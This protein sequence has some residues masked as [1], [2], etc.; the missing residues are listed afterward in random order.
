MNEQFRDDKIQKYYLARVIQKPKL[1]SDTLI[2]WLRKDS[3][4]HYA[5]VY[6]QQANDTQYAEL[7]FVVRKLFAKGALLEIKLKT[8][9]FHQIRAQLAKIGCTIRGDLKYGAPVPNPDKSICLHAYKIM[10]NHPVTGE[11]LSIESNPPKVDFW[12]E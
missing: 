4:K 8:G 1:E 10:F 2:H 7:S 6:N 11:L 5:V 3:K 9:R 12:A